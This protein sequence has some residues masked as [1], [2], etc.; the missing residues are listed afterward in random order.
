M[1]DPSDQ[2]S[3]GL[4]LFEYPETWQT[5]GRYTTYKVP[6]KEHIHG[7]QTEPKAQEFMMWGEAKRGDGTLIRSK[8]AKGPVPKHYSSLQSYLSRPYSGWDSDGPISD[9]V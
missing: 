7:L 1:L 3:S 4:S 2:R 5:M 6:V 8:R 9:I